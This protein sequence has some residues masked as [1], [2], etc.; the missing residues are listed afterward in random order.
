MC[1]PLPY[2]LPEGSIVKLVNM[3]LIHWLSLILAEITLKIVL[4]LEANQDRFQHEM[5]GNETSTAAEPT[6]GKALCAISLWL[7]Y[8]YA[9]F[10]PIPLSSMIK[11]SY[12]FNFIDPIVKH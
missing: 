4:I 12:N 8:N 9:S 7:I 1:A 5:S 6:V 10:V 3:T 11:T 2:G